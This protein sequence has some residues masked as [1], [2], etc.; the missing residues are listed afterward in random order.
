MK[1]NILTT[2]GFVYVTYAILTAYTALAS[3]EASYTESPPTWAEPKGLAQVDG[4]YQP[5]DFIDT[6]TYANVKGEYRIE[7]WVGRRCHWCDKF[8]K[9]EL[10][11]LEK[12]GVRV[13]I[14]ETWKIPKSE[15][16][17]DLR[18][19]PTIK[20]YRRT[21]CIKTYHGYEKAETVLSNVKHKV[22]LL[23]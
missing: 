1:R 17:K 4:H 12:S 6:P 23:R 9:R 8:K 16:P 15:R 3:I 5:M 19:V 14:K 11:K 10:P 7:V 18:V 21:K 2:L 20:V 22:V 13:E